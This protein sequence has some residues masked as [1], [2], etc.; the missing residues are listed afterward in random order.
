MIEWLR[1]RLPVIAFLVLCSSGTLQ[2]AWLLRGM[3]DDLLVRVDHN[4]EANALREVDGF[5]ALGLWHDAGLGRPLFG[6]RYPE[7]GFAAP[8]DPNVARYLSPGGVYTHFPPGPEYIL[9]GAEALF[10]PAPVWR[11]RLVPLALTWAAALFLGLSLRR[12]YGESVAWLVMLGCAALPSF[13]DVDIALHV[14]GYAMALFLVEIGVATGRHRRALPFLLIGFLQGWISF[15][16]VFLVALCPLALELAQP[17]LIP[18]TPARL[19]LG[20]LRSALAGGGFAL[21][22][23]AHFGQV[24]AYYGSLGQAVADLAA[25]AQYRSGLGEVH[26]PLQYLGNAI[27]VILYNTCSV[28]PVSVFFWHPDADFPYRIWVFRF[29]GL[30]FAP[31]WVIVSVILG[32]IDHARRRAGRA[33][34]RLLVR[35]G[36]ISLLGLIVSTCWW[37]VMQ[38]HAMQHWFM[39]FRHLFFWFFLSLL[40]VAV[41]AAPAVGRLLARRRAALLAA[42]GSG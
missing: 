26:G 41:N 8:S 9:Y 24:W 13:H 1:Q 32:V 22:H 19:R 5:R 15:D 33:D 37:L 3:G 29:L 4:S 21:A 42:T 30:T 11:L 20:V 16:W 25:S 2:A 23:L 35:W 40:F 6:P 12:R 34:A 7:L 17:L 14:W 18:G 38:N 31:W 27:N 10:G 28:F 36:G 39:N